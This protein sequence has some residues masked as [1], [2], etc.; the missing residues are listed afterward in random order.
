MPSIQ[1]KTSA[2]P[3]LDAF[4]NQTLN[5]SKSSSSGANPTSTVM[6]K[7]LQLQDDPPFNVKKK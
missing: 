4:L 5:K 7:P 2:M 6:P 1:G 3:G